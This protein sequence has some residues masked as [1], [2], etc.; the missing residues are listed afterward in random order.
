MSSIRNLAKRGLNLNFNQ[1][2]GP[3]TSEYYEKFLNDRHVNKLIFSDDGPEYHFNINDLVEMETIA[4]TRYVIKRMKHTPSKKEMAVKFVHIPHNRHSADDENLKKLKHLVKEIQNFRE[5]RNE[6]NIVRFYGFCLY[7]GQALICALSYWPPERLEHDKAKLDVL[8]DIWSLGITLIEIVTGSVPYRDRKGNIPNNI[9]LLQNLILNLDTSKT[10]EDTMGGYT[11]GI[12]NFMK[13]CLKKV[14]ER[15][16]H[17]DLMATQFYKC[18]EKIELEKAVQILLKKYYY[19]DLSIEEMDTSEP[20][21]DTPNENSIRTLNNTKENLEET[22][23]IANMAHLKYNCDTMFHYF[24]ISRF[25]GK[26][27][28]QGFSN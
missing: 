9:I 3:S 23:T 20:N 27:K 24:M 2:Q 18:C 7:E 21:V 15:P 17:D 5:L 12:K 8:A 13:S 16:K 6:P 14:E 22:L 10:V 11:E 25:L 4:T 28:S 19:Q 1:V 26:P